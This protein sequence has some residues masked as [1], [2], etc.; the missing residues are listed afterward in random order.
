MTTV[1]TTLS[2]F[3]LVFG[4]L[5]S[6]RLASG[7]FAQ[8]NGAKMAAQVYGSDSHDFVLT[9]KNYAG[10]NASK[11]S[12]GAI[13]TTMDQRFEKGAA[14]MAELAMIAREFRKPK[15]PAT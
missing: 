11:S 8:L 15:D 14:F 4:A 1:K 12:L 5:F 10:R 9:R 2:T 7:Y 13:P 3:L 6:L